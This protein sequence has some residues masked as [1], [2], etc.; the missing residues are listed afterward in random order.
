MTVLWGAFVVGLALVSGINLLLMAGVVH[1]L[2]DHSERLGE[3]SVL[4]AMTTMRPP[5]GRIEPFSARTTHHAELAST[6]LRGL[7]LVGAFAEGCPMCQ[8]S[9]PG[10]LDLA[11][12]SPEGPA[13]VVALLVGS[14]ANLGEERRLL[15]PVAQVVEEETRDGVA[16][17]L[18]IQGFPAIGLINADTGAVLASGSKANQV[19]RFMIQSASS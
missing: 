7:V 1:R 12:R 11:R 17:A 4:P 9:M 3:L 16:K 5:D 2:R 19:E 8:E 6:A 18:G 14:A 10:F 15:E 13:Q